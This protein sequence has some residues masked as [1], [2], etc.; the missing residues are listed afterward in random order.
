MQ[1]P[2]F[3]DNAAVLK[4]I[5]KHYL[6]QI[7]SQNCLVHQFNSETIRIL[8]T[9]TIKKLVTTVI[10]RSSRITFKIINYY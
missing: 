10:K 6:Q 7:Q 5:F 3:L 4:T 9:S 8:K 2:C 1:Y